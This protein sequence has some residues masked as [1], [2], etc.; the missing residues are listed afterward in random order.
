M[1]NRFLQPGFYFDAQRQR[2][3]QVLANGKTRA[4][5]ESVLNRAVTRLATDTRNEARELT[6]Q[7]VRGEITQDVWYQQM[8]T[9]M[10]VSYRTSVTVANGGNMTP[11]DWGRFGAEMK[12]Q[13]QYLDNFRA[14]ILS[15]KQPLNGRAVVRAGMYGDAN[16]AQYQNWKLKQAVRAGFA[17]E[18]KRTL[19][20][21]EHCPDCLEYAGRGWVPADEVVPIGSSQCKVH[22]KCTIQTRKVKVKK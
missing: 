11:A 1:L 16:Y 21:A 9:Q 8:R 7:L 20:P 12:K 14:E 4:V 6:A 2:Y 3:I 15:G 19:H 22:C 18:A 5:A 10:R 13:Y 17:L